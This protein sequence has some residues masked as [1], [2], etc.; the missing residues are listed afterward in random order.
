MPY[1]TLDG[2][3]THYTTQGSGPHLLMMAPRG[4]NS[5]IQSW[6]GGMWKEMDVFNA[7]SKHFTLIA[8][9]RREAGLSGGRVEVLTWDVFAQHGKLLL[10]HLGVEK[11]W[12]I[13]PCMGV[14]VAAQFGV[15]YPESC[16]GLMLPQPVGGH[17]WFTRLRSF[18]DRHV[19]FVRE[20]GLQ[21]VVQRATSE[22][23]NF[24][25]DPEAGPWATPIKND[26]GFAARYVKQDVERYLNIVQASR[27]ALFPSSDVSG[28]SAEDL[29]A[30]EI[31]CLVWSG[32]DASHATSAAHQLRE[33]LS[34]VEYWDV[35]VAKQTHQGQLEQ[36][37]KFKAAVEAG[38]I[39][40]KVVASR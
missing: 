9:D 30:L 7:L 32:D 2:I 35:N 16:I 24:Q 15:R 25:D 20:N 40:K 33:L 13:G 31:L 5:R 34:Y 23:K 27:D 1:A 36:I 28:P 38:S 22:G 12:V 3:K 10:D 11:T 21:A 19:K 4:F 18:F 6:D 37:L 29:M 26:A 17:R 8:Y 39:V 14:A